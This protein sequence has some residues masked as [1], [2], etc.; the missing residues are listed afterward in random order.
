MAHIPLFPLPLVVFPGGR[1]PLQIFETRYVDMVKR[2]LREGSGFGVIMI[3]EG[4][5][6]LRD[7]EQQLPSV[8]RYGTY[9]SIVDFDELPNGMLGIMAEGVKKFVI[10]D[11]YEQ[12]DRLMMGD[13]EFLPDETPADM[14]DEQEHLSS[15][16]ESLMSHE[17]VQRL[18]LGCDMTQAGEVGAR[19]TELLPCPNEFKQ[20]MLEI[21]DPLIRLGELDKMVDAIQKR[22][23]GRG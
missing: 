2:C 13:V 15:L 6:V 4:D 23:S 12:V 22:Q 1:L 19:L 18:G 7:T 11:E 20:R 9:C 16:L 10:R 21:K 17:A 5:Q 14:P 8:S 3:T